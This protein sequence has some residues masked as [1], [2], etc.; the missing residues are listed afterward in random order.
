MAEKFDRAAFYR[1]IHDIVVQIP[2]G[3]V[4]TYGS[5]ARLAGYPQHARAVGQALRAAPSE[6]DLPCHRVVN[7]AGGVAP[8]WPEQRELLQAEGI[9]FTRSGHVDMKCHLWDFEVL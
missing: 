6:L 5:I 1:E 7:H 3:K 4:L 2:A 8:G 9:S